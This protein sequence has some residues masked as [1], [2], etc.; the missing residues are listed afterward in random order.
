M[1]LETQPMLAEHEDTNTCVIQQGEDITDNFRPP[2]KNTKYNDGPRWRLGLWWFG[3]IPVAFVFGIIGYGYIVFMYCVII[4]DI[5][6]QYWYWGITEFCIVNFSVFMTLASYIQVVFQ[7]PGYIPQGWS[8]N[9]VERGDI[10][11]SISKTCRRC[12]KI[13]PDRV[14]HCRICKRCVL[15]MDHHCP[16]VNNCVGFK[17]YKFFI[18]FVSYVPIMAVTTILVTIPYIILHVDFSSHFP[19]STINVFVVD[20]IAV[21]FGLG[22]SGFA[23]MHFQLVL[24]NLTT[25]E[26][27]DNRF[28]SKYQKRRSGRGKP[29][30]TPF[31]L[32]KNE[33]FKQ[34]FG[35]NKLLWWI[36]IA[37][38]K[39]DGL[40]YP[41]NPKFVLHK[42]DDKQS[43]SDCENEIEEKEDK[44]DKEDKEEKEDV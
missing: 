43:S 20:L 9:A 27:M 18:L 29:D 19:T 39:G 4:P 10:K 23:I 30:E 16:W 25:L 11:Q 13:K 34:V 22:L 3:L 6:S 7:S 28:V 40:S 15:K 17:N 31:D 35:D 33:N 38:Y 12:G 2:P 5:M 26:S 8:E 21:V 24:T 44:E 1:S 36:P 41:M 37:S 32:G 42:N 14:H